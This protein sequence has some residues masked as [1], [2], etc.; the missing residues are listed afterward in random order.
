MVEAI[1]KVVCFLFGIGMGV[2]SLMFFHA[3]FDTHD[4]V[5]RVL[6]RLEAMDRKDGA[7]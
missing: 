3:I 1:I 2:I 4:K 7:S 5:K 6:A